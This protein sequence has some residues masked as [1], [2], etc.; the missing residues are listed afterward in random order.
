MVYMMRKQ[1][2]QITK[3]ITKALFLHNEY[4]VIILTVILLSCIMVLSVVII[5]QIF[6]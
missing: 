5:N 4:S 1:V 3:K 6:I 2:K